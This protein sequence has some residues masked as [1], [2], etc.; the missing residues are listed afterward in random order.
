MGS[1]GA[2]TAQ[3]IVRVAG[4]AVLGLV[5]I[6]ASCG[7]TSE[8]R[9]EVRGIVLEVE[10]NLASV[11]SFLLRTDDG[12]L[13]RVV[14]APGGDFR[15]P[16]PH[17][18]DHLR[19]SEPLLVELDRSYDP[20]RATAIRDADNPAWHGE[21]RTEPVP[22]QAG[23]EQG[24]TTAGQEDAASAS[25]GIEKD[26]GPQ[27]DEPPSPPASV[28]DPESGDE[29]GTPPASTATTTSTTAATDTP[30]ETPGEG[31]DP[32][33]GTSDETPES[34]EQAGS[35]QEGTGEESDHEPIEPTEPAEPAGPVIDLVIVD[36]KLDGGAR[37]EP[38]RLGDTV[39]IRVTGNSDDEVH[40]HGYDLF[41]HLVDGAGELTFEASIP[42]IFEIELEGPHTLLVRLEVS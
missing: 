3:D 27:G 12:E 33:R 23:D 21:V 20:P 14:P 22:R 38:V 32:S 34:P 9:E 6:V 30:L 24:P 28:A 37:R 16:L 40:V 35:D 17:L 10:G 8:H 15:F 41:V 29:P 5:L 42:G 13:L 31:S 19:T 18:H 36:G 1:P 2:R 25:P 39:T 11:E 26:P 4:A 7:D